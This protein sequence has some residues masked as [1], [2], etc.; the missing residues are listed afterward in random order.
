MLTQNEKQSLSLKVLIWI[1]NTLEIITTLLLFNYVQNIL[2]EHLC[3]F[4]LLLVM[5]LFVFMLY[6]IISQTV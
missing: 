6:K 4:I 1:Y 2:D 5:A 3:I